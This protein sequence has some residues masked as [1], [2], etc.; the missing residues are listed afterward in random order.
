MLIITM[1]TTRADHLGCYGHQVPTSPFIDSI[2]KQGTLFRNA[3]TSATWTLPAHISLFTG[4][5]PTVHG[6][7]YSNYFASPTLQTLGEILR[8]KGYVT[9]GFTGGPFLDSV[10]NVHQGFQYYDEKLDSN[11]KL[12]RLTLFRLLSRF[13]FSFW[14]TDGQRNAEDTNR[15]LFPFLSWAS[16]NQPFFIFVNYFDPHEPYNPPDKYRKMLNIQT[17]FKGNIRFY[18]LDKKTG[19]A[20]HKNGMPLRPEEF[21]ALRSLYDGEIR[22][23][24]D[25]IA[26]LWKL[27]DSHH[28]LQNTLIILTSDH[29]ES[30]GEH[31]FLDHGHNLYQEQVRIPLILTGIP[32]WKSGIQV[33]QNAQI[34]DIFP[35]I[36]EE[37]RIPLP[38]EIQGR[39]LMGTISTNLVST[40]IDIDPHPR[41]AAFRRE[42]KMILQENQKYVYSSDHQDQLFHLGT[43]P[44]EFHNLIHETPQEASALEK[45]LHE[46]FQ[47]LLVYRHV[48][49]GQMDEETREKLKALGYIE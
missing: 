25:Q 4:Q 22:T 12:K 28:L 14:T 31:Q 20:R 34:T 48:G 49:K 21:E 26:A 24:D 19:I 11:S 45:R 27:L 1:D 47:S 40:E 23:M 9:A 38:K 2:A 46:Y 35:T 30:I 13:G 15:A 7:G 32:K 36:L 18:P 3:Y 44:A 29:G 6:V 39:N 42:Q 41:F 10:F 37:L 43:D 33:D 5:M 17:N 16:K 8:D